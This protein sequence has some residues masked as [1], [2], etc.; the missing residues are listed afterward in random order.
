LFLNNNS[1]DLV[2]IG[3]LV[4]QA[5]CRAALSTRRCERHE[6]VL[7]EAADESFYPHRVVPNCLRRLSMYRFQSG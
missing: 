6:A 1:L 7:N 5:G 3:G 2:F 4:I